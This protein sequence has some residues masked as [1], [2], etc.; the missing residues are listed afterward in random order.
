M[1]IRLLAIGFGGVARPQLQYF[2]FLDDVELVAGAD[3]D[4]EAR[5]WFEVEFDA[6]A[7]ESHD[8]LLT[9][10]AEAADAVSIIT[11]H[12]F[13]HEQILDSFAA[14]L[15]VYVEKPMVVGLEEAVDVVSA[16][17]RG[18]RILQVGY[19]RHF[20]PL[21]QKLKELIEAGRIGEPHFASCYLEQ[22]WINRR[23]GTWRTDPAVSGGGQLYDSGS[24][25]LD[26]LLWTTGGK[27]RRVAAV[28]R[29]APDHPGVDVD[30]AVSATLDRNGTPLTASIAVTADGPTY[31]ETAERLVVIGTDGK[32]EFGE[33]ALV[34]SEQGVDP[35]QQ[36]VDRIELD[37]DIDEVFMAKM[38]DFIAA[39]RGE[40]PPAVPAEQALPVTVLTEAAYEANRRGETID[41]RAML[42][43]ARAASPDGD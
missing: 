37:V 26:A 7:Y 34:V 23:T 35:E 10:H 33:G 4:S 20:H 2:A 15:D 43:Q 1:P 16:A 29:D 3:V 30:S 12:S 6:P 40:T 25:L 21:Y 18:G 8:G 27:P 19:Q 17:N 39:V 5:D 22:D 38:D 32:I 36:T 24:H 31:P 42:E 28:M 14:G 11:P 41:A 9:N 13:H